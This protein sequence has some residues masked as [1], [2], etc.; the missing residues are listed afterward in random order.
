[1]IAVLAAVSMSENA[2]AQSSGAT[3]TTCSQEWQRCTFSGTRNVRY[4]ANGVYAPIRAFTN[5]LDCKNTSFGGDPLPG[6]TKHCA[7]ESGTTTPPPTTPPPTNPPPTNPPPAGSTAHVPYS[8]N[9]P[10][11]YTNDHPEDVHTDVIMMALHSNGT[12]DLRGIVTDQQGSSPSGCGGDGCHTTA[13]D[14]AKRREWISAARS[15]GFYDIP[16]SVSGDA[17]VNLIVAEA[18][19]ASSSL[20]LVIMTGG[21]LTLVAR[22]YRLDPSIASRV[23][24][25]IAGFALNQWTSGKYRGET[26]ITNDLAAAQ[27]VLQNMRCV[28]VPFRD[29]NS[30]GIDQTRYPATP[31]SRVDALP[32]KPLR[33]RMQSIYAYPWA[34]YDADGGPQATLLSTRYATASKRVRWATDSGGSYLADDA[35][36]DDVLITSVD[37]APA[38]DR[39]WAEVR[40]AFGAP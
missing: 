13:I 40:E 9:N 16:S 27:T 20:P 32:N 33:A 28:I 6:V 22:A 2:S 38:T 30:Q 1:M 11:L 3:W 35:N 10:I 24:V 37:A 31:R 26:N 14:D 39:W 7:I 29:F 23:I 36:S 4:G 21:P 34:H 19:A 8:T 18:R 17:A 5:G 25:S 15:S 12:I